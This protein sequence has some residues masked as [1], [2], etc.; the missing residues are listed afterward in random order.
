MNVRLSVIAVLAV[1][2]ALNAPATEIFRCSTAKGGVAYQ[3]FPCAPDAQAASF[4]VPSAYPEVN[5]AAREQLLRREAALDRRLE[6]ARERL[7]R[8]EMT[9]TAA[10][11][12]APAN[13][14]AYVIAWPARIPHAMGPVRRVRPGVLQR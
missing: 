2:W 1:G 5:A 9:R 7:S 4:Q 11:A 6:A 10:R 13:E 3:E 8:E 12:Q 14:P